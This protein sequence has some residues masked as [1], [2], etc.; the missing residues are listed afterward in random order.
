MQSERLCAKRYNPTHGSGWFCSIP[1][2]INGNA[3]LQIP[4]TAV[5]GW[6]IQVLVWSATNEVSTNFRWWD[7]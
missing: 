6:F 4:P 5:G 2:Y 1:T 3:L 7:F